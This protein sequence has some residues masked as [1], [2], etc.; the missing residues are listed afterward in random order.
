MA[1]RAK[2]PRCAPVGGYLVPVSRIILDGQRE[3]PRS[4]DVWLTDPTTGAVGDGRWVL[5]STFLDF[6]SHGAASL[7]TAPSGLVMIARPTPADLCHEGWVS[8][9][10]IEASDG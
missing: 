1:S 10:S 5:A 2:F 7:T 9:S 6:P 3:T 4:W 8:A